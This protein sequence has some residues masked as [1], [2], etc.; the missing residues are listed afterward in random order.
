MILVVVIAFWAFLFGTVMFLVR[1]VARDC[2]DEQ[3]VCE[4]TD[5]YFTT[6]APN[7][8]AHTAAPAM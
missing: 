5:G 2:D 1:W 3:T 7:T 8:Q 6:T 4:L